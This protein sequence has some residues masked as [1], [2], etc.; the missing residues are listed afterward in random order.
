MFPSNAGR[1]TRNTAP[2]VNRQIRRRTERNIARVSAAGRG[3]AMR[4]LAELDREW[5]IERTLQANAA[6][7]VVLGTAL[8]ALKDRR[9]HLVPAV[10][11]GFLLQ[12][13]L[14]GWCPPLNVF[15][16]LGIRT[17]AEIDYERDKLKAYLEGAQ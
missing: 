17:E 7:L 14:Q 1:V 10:V 16:R 5:D 6:T 11:G 12:H 15:R 9:F 8:G 4:R 3:A 13:A 2:Q